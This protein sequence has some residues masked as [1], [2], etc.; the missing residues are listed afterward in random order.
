L[1]YQRSG[2]RIIGTA[3][4]SWLREDRTMLGTR[5]DPLFGAR[6]SNAVIADLSAAWRPATDWSLGL[7]WRGLWARPDRAGRLTD[8]AL[9]AQAMAVDVTRA[10]LFASGDTL[11]LRLAQPLRLTRGGVA[12]TLPTAYDYASAGATDTRQFLP[13]VPSGRELAA[14]A[15]YAIP[16]GTGRLSLNG[17][18]RRDPGHRAA[19]GD[20]R[21]AAIRFVLGY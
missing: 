19:A 15:A 2:D 7:G 12:L 6:G 5:F 1:G 9:F 4:L 3:T 20:D 16:L 10:N 14:E 8:G 11:A 13:L 17:W 21:G 18:W